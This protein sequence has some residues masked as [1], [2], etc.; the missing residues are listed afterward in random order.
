MARW[1]RMATIKYYLW[2]N[3]L[4]DLSVTLFTFLYGQRQS[5]ATCFPP[6]GSENFCAGWH[7]DWFW[8]Y[9]VNTNRKIFFLIRFKIR[10][11]LR[12]ICHVRRE[13]FF[14]LNVLI[15]KGLQV[16][17]VKI[18]WVEHKV[19]GYID[20]LRVKSSDILKIIYINSLI[21]IMPFFNFQT[22]Q[23]SI[24]NWN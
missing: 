19:Q 12:L 24:N 10:R 21:A 5:N 22:W 17:K 20:M 7:L 1:Y 9:A 16:D 4:W 13:R 2:I 11:T 8:C 3:Y 6:L 15:I 23:F 14:H 18:R